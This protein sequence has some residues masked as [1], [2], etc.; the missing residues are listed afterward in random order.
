MTELARFRLFCEYSPTMSDKAVSSID[1]AAVSA[2]VFDLGGVLIDGGPS[3][4]AAFGTRVGLDH[5]DWARLRRDLF[6]NDGVWSALERGETSFDHFIEVIRESIHAAGGEV[7]EEAAAAF[8]GAPDP[9][10]RK[11]RL[12]GDMLDGVR[13]LKQKMPTALLTNNV[14]EWREGW[15][16]I[17]DIPDLFDLVIDSSEEGTRKPEQRI[18]EITQSRLGVAH[19][20]IFFLDDIG[21]NLKAARHLGWQTML[22]TD[23]DSALAVMDAVVDAARP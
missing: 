13:R 2:A 20:N 7:S 6:G 23:Q 22:Y 17:L 16:S 9:M 14:K 5:A 21:Q 4:V 3:D 18:Y 19:E 11:N 10:K 8:M 12:R 15:R 1:P